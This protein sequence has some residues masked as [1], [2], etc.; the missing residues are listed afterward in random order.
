MIIIDIPELPI[1]VNKAFRQAGRFRVRTRDYED[2][3]ALVELHIP[4]CPDLSSSPLAVE[5]TLYKEDWF[6]KKGTIRRADIDNYVKTCLDSIFKH[7][8]ADD[9]QVFQLKVVKEHGSSPRT[10]VKIYDLS[11]N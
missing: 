4:D 2:W 10:L 5:I 11:V 3:L 6:T 7:L 8:N 9:S 1:S